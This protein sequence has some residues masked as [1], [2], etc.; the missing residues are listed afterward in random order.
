MVAASQSSSAQSVGSN[1]S[2]AM[3]ASG[4]SVSAAVTRVISTITS[5]PSACR[6]GIWLVRAVARSL[7]SLSS[8]AKP[9]V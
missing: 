1:R 4:A 7:P 3:S 6:T 5:W 2:K 9:S 8:R